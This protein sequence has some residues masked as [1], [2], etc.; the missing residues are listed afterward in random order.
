MGGLLGFASIY[1]NGLLALLCVF[2]L[3]GLLFVR[4]FHIPSF[5]QRWFAVFLSSLAANHLFVTLIAALQLDPLPTYRIALATLVVILILVTVM[6]PVG[7]RKPVDRAASIVLMSDI[8]WLLAALALVCLVYINVWKYGVPH[9]FDDGD[10]AVSWNRWA[11]VWSQGHFPGS[12]GY[13]QFIPTLWAVTYIFTGSI[14]QYF[15]YY[16]YIVLIIAPLLFNAMILGRINWWLPLVQGLAFAWFVAEI[17]EQWLRSTLPQAFPDWVAAISGFCGVVLFIANAPEGRFDREKIASALLSLCLVSIAAATKPIFGLFA[18]AI[19]LA[20][21]TD[22]V[23]GL[24]GRARYKLCIGAIGVLSLFAAA[25]AIDYSHLPSRGMPNYPVADLSERL[26]RA[27]R[28]LNANFTIPF[29]LLL[30]AGVLL[31]P[32]LARARWLALP[33]W[34]GLFVWA[35]TA[36]YDLRNVLGL[37]MVSAFIPL[38]AAARACD[39]RKALPAG[40]SWRAP[41]GAVAVIVAVMAAGLTLT[42]ALSDRDLRQR[43]ADDQLRGGSGMDINQAIENVLRRGC[44]IF[45]AT[46]YISTISAF[47]PFRKQMEFFFFSLPLDEPLTRRFNESTGCTG[48]FYPPDGTHPTIVRFLGSYAEARDLVKVIEG[49]GMVLMATSVRGAPAPENE[50]A[51]K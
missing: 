46:G 7:S 13:P 49:N 41:D 37:L 50:V 40:R 14:V 16:I 1:I 4:A 38:F 11:L 36:S 17:Q 51:D 26:W 47:D 45:S 24:E 34:V 12:I 30:L 32:I 10:V 43:F 25:Y 33:L 8:G 28:L 18:I 22:A 27:V 44:T 39:T 2:V 21:C 35:N 15:A 42:L 6:Q 20:I 23:R 31:C 48:V 3:P 29:K 19:L 5:P 9:I